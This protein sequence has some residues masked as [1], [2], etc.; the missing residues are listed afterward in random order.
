MPYNCAQFCG[1][2]LLSIVSFLAQ[3]ICRLLFNGVLHVTCL[4]FI[5]LFQKYNLIILRLIFCSE[6][7][8]G[9]G[10]SKKIATFITNKLNQFKVGVNAFSN[11]AWYLN[12][13]INQD[14][15]SLPYSSYKIK[16][17]K[18]FLNGWQNKLSNVRVS[19]EM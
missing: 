11:W 4:L 18:L 10:Q 19:C 15:L 2:Q 8:T 5:H 9:P 13:K 14:W 17:K 12:G 1:T 16:C 3:R 6:N 7:K